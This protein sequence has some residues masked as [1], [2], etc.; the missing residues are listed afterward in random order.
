M[1]D[2]YEVPAES[3]VKACL[4]IVHGAG[5]HYRRHQAV[6]N[7]FAKAGFYV[8]MG[9]LPGHG[10]AKGMHGHIDD[11]QTYLDA[12]ASWAQKLKQQFPDVPRFILGH[13]M[14]GLITA[15]FIQQ[16]DADNWNGV[17]L[18]SPCLGIA[19]P[20]PGWKKRIANILEKW[21]PTLRLK[22]GIDKDALCRDP[23][24]V[25][26][27]QKD[28]LVVKKVSVKWFCELQRAISR[29]HEEVDRFQVPVLITQGGADRVV[30]PR[31]TRRWY[32]QLEVED[33]QLIWVADG[34]HE[35]LQEF[36]KY[37]LMEKMLA[38]TE[39]R[40]T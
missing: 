11:F 29:A 28:P 37:D 36:V 35:L 31:A 2:W 13:S 19:L 8:G 25:D 24:V 23:Q 40:L 32:N 30:D 21:W 38:W 16:Q 18:S 12:V 6:A 9:D 14:G 20:I 22:S 15:R 1:E 33:K 7:Y 3:A 27:Y 5:E 10:R 4:L 26:E 39:N 34:Y 17:L